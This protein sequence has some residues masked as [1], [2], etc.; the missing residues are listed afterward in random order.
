[1]W[2]RTKGGLEQYP[3]ETASAVWWILVEAGVVGGAIVALVIGL[4]LAWA[5]WAAR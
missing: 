2:N 1:M 3:S 4:V 5:I